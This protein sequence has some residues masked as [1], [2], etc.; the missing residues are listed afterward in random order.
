MPLSWG[1]AA[2]SGPPR[3]SLW[4]PRR[5]ALH[6]PC[7]RCHVVVD[8]RGRGLRKRP[9]VQ[10]GNHDLCKTRG[11]EKQIEGLGAAPFCV[12]QDSSIE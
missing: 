11:G 5:R 3:Y 9:A 8:G 10:S 12:Q 6:L 7:Q 1:A 4:P 2:P